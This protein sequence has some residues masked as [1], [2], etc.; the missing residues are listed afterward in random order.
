[1]HGLHYPAGGLTGLMI[2]IVLI[3]V[4]YRIIKGNPSEKPD[5]TAREILDERYA[6]GEIDAQQ[7][8]E[9]KKNISE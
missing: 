7:Y 1:M 8:K 6:R 9:Q 2:L 3:I 5:K 4:A